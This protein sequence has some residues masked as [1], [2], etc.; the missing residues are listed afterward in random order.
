MKHLASAWNGE[1]KQQAGL[2]LL[3]ALKDTLGTVCVRAYTRLSV[4]RTADVNSDG[5]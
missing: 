5:T 1:Q 2:Y 4:I 3:H